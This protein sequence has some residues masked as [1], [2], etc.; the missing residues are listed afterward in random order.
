M[1]YKKTNKKKMKNKKKKKKNNKQNSIKST[2]VDTTNYNKIK[3][4]F[5]SK[6]INFC[7]HFQCNFILC[8]I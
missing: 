4:A 5:Q 3:P 7:F 1:K 2:D 6:D 8:Y